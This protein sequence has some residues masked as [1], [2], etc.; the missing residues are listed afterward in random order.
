MNKSCYLT[1]DSQTN[2]IW[3][4]EFFKLVP[5][6]KNNKY[7]ICEVMFNCNVGFY[8]EYV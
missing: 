5:N 8:E 2:C 1:P 6:P 7:K 4:V 3:C